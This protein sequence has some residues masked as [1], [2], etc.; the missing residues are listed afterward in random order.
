M[1]V[2]WPKV[3]DFVERVSA[4][5]AFTFLALATTTSLTDKKQI[6]AAALAGA[7]SAGKYAYVQLGAYLKES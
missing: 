6:E 7:L 1:K 5:F 3:V 4:T 2:N